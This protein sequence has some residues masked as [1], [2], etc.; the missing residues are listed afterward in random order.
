MAKT[1]INV[2][3]LH[4]AVNAARETRGLS[5]R[6][7]AKDMGVSPSLLSRMGNGF[8][9]DA[10]GFA[11]IV[12]WLGMPAETFMDGDERGEAE[13]DLAAELAPLLRA[14]KDLHSD[15]VRYLE[16]VVQATLRR[17]KAARLERR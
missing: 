5:W 9:P 6:Q 8:R 7:A 2:A 17:A 10:D 13:P 11:T 12:R 16:E 3:G 15:D 1:R 4:G 14:S